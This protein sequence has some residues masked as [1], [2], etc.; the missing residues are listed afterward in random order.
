M[1]TSVMQKWG[2]SD[3]VFLCFQ[4][5][6]FVNFFLAWPLCTRTLSHLDLYGVS[7][8]RKFSTALSTEGLQHSWSSPVTPAATRMGKDSS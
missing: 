5:A 1:R 8:E 3:T 4:G 6:P 7:T 2:P